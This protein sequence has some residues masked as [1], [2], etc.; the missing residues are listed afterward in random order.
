M[1]G[2]PQTQEAEA[3]TRR[4]IRLAHGARKKAERS[5]ATALLLASAEPPPNETV[6]SALA[7]AA[8]QRARALVALSTVKRREFEV[9]AQRFETR[10]AHARTVQL[11][12]HWAKLADAETLLLAQG[13]GVTLT[14]V[15]TE[16]PEWLRDDAGTLVREYGLPVLRVERTKARRRKGGLELIAQ[17]GRLTAAQVETG[18]WWARVCADVAKAGLGARAETGL[19]AGA[20]GKPSQGPADWKLA[21]VGAKRQA[22]ATVLA[23]LPGPEGAALLAL[24]EAVCFEGRTCWDLARKDDREAARLEERVAMGLAMLRAGR[25]SQAAR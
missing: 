21:A 12:A 2:E 25:L 7:A 11:D 15:E 6:K 14:P 16:V 9:A 17:K 22:E 8:R 18:E 3:A 20:R 4:R 19:P 10:A 5:R 24:L 23:V 13:R 1:A